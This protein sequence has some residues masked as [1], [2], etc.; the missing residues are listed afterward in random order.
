MVEKSTKYIAALMACTALPTSAAMAQS[1]SPEITGTVGA[2][3]RTDTR[4]YVGLAWQFGRNASPKPQVVVGVQ[5]IRIDSD[6]GLSGVDLNLRF[7]LD[8]R[9]GRVALSGL[10]G[11]RG[12]HVNLVGGYDFTTREAFGTAA[13]Q[14]TGLR[15]GADLGVRTGSLRPYLELNSLSKPVRVSGKSSVLGCSTANYVPVSQ[16]QAAASPNPGAIAI[17]DFAQSNGLDLD[18]L[19]CMDAG[20]L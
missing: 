16:S 8:G 2:D 13:L 10:K 17:Y 1:F 12:A 6:D 7:G 19:V 4:A 14:G 18:G 9:N 15:I 20:F 3:R 5:K 11:R